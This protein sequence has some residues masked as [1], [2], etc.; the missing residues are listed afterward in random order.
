M[1]FSN[2]DAV[3]S[4]FSEK[5]YKNNPGFTYLYPKYFKNKRKSFAKYVKDFITLKDLIE[6]F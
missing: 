2:F 5:G 6:L 1:E 3:A 4:H